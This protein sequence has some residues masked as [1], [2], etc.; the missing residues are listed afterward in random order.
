MSL[1]HIF[2]ATG[3][4]KTTVYRILETFVHRGYVS[5]SPEGYI[6]VRA[7]RGRCGS[8]LQARVTTCRFRRR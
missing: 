1:E 7:G 2:R 6:G 5:Q 3:L 4:S 8:G